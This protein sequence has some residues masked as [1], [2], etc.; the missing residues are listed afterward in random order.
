M[1]RSAAVFSLAR[2]RDE[3]AALR[4]QFGPASRRSRRSLLNSVIRDARGAQP[5]EIADCLPVLHELLL[6]AQAYPEDAATERLAAR[7]QDALLTAGRNAIAALPAE[8][9][10]RGV[11]NR[12]EFSL[13]LC[14]WLGNRLGAR[15]DVDW[16]RL[17]DSSALE[18]LL[19]LLAPQ[20]G[21]DG[22]MDDSLDCPAW[23]R[24]ARGGR[25]GG[26]LRW[27]IRRLRQCVPSPAAADRLFD[28]LSLPVCWTLDRRDSRSDLRFPSRP[29]FL[30]REP[31]LRTADPREWMNRRLPRP[32]SLSRSA[33]RELIATARLSLAARQRETD[34]VT[35]ADQRDVALFRL[36][37]GVDVALFGMTPERRLPIETY[38][39]FVAA[40]NRVP[41]AYGGG[42]A[43]LQRC[44]IGVNV[45]DTF[46]GGESALLFSQI[47]RVYRQWFGVRRFEVDP[48]QFGRDNEE[49]IASGAYWFY[50]RLGFRSA[51]TAAARM[52][53]REAARL[54]ASRD[55]RTP[56]AVL[57]RLARVP[58]AM[59][60]DP[61]RE[62]ADPVPLASLS[63]AA[64]R[65]LAKRYGDD[66]ERAAADCTR[67]V[68]RLTGIRLS[69]PAAGLA[70]L[71]M[72][73]PDFGNWPTAQRR[74]AAAAIHAKA[75][76]SER[77]YV[78]KLQAH[79]R[80]AAAWTH[81]ARKEQQRAANVGESGE[82]APGPERT[83][84]G[85]G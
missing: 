4:T 30:Q 18:Q 66:L 72:M 61:Q 11:V 56:A 49:A 42:W 51:E 73:I 82:D 13:D 70:P 78:R 31:I 10:L 33:A 52:A 34:P 20:V 55:A 69:G 75:G 24:I 25:A 35:Y 32:Q 45:F 39:G 16:P 6:F 71:L 22:A 7:A 38:V 28:G 77:T 58:L 59:H 47:L 19:T 48:Y 29:L 85:R 68:Q 36:E 8:S 26:D 15:F 57:R 41:C 9:G 23:L 76:R 5:S 62:S 84:T 12:A 21:V 63:L 14:E 50:Y 74:A 46:R 60:C 80:L 37:R 54:A 40:R 65:W 17:A 1:N 2:L 3:L 79:P 81:L 27:I 44:E 43:F 67:R 83:A 64:T 53:D